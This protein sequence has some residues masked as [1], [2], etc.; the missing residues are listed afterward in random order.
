MDKN[1]CLFM[2]VEKCVKKMEKNQTLT[3]R[4]GQ[5]LCCFSP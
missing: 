1:A 4:I 2:S 5:R 3:D